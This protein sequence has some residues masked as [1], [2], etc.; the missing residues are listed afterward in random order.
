MG[1]APLIPE[2]GKLE[3]EGQEFKATYSILGQP[4]LHE[5]SLKTQKGGG[6]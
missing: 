6:D 5:L 4:E 3:Q 2:F 1:Y